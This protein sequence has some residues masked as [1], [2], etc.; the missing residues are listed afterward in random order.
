MIKKTYTISRFDKQIDTKTYTLS[1][2]INKNV[3][4]KFTRV[5]SVNDFKSHNI[6]Y[7]V[8]STKLTGIILNN[9]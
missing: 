9:A 7:R 1:D 5:A 4:T 6:D 3:I 8:R 2:T